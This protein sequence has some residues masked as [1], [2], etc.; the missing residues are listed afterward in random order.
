MKVLIL[1]VAWLIL[2]ALSWPLAL[3][4]LVVAPL[5]WLIALPFRLLAVVV[6]A[7]FALIKS[8]LFLPGANSRTSRDVTGV[9]PI[10]VISRHSPPSIDES[11]SIAVCLLDR[12]RL[13]DARRKI[14]RIGYLGPSAETAPHLLKA[15]QDGLATLGCVEGRNIVVEYR[16]T[17]AGNNMTSEAACLPMRASWSLRRSTSSSRRSIRQSSPRRKPPR[18]IAPPHSSTEFCEAR[19]PPIFRSSNRPNSSSRST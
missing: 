18:T 6:G 8:L 14:F 16:W 13:A 17:N 15:F 19:N 7:T 3:L 4:A 9:S 1:F 12:G 11:A 10:A 2:L 5:L